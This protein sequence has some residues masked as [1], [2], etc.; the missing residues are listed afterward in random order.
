MRRP[1]EIT[2]RIDGYAKAKGSATR[3]KAMRSLLLPGL[4]THYEAEQKHAARK[5]KGK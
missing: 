3:S 4:A 1:D 2:A 5:R